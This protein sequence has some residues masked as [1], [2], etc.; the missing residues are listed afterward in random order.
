[1]DLISDGTVVHAGTFNGNPLAMAAA[2]ATIDELGRDDGEAYRRLT[3][4][5]TRLMEG[6]RG[7]ASA[8]G[9]PVLLQGPGPVFY[10]WLTDAPAVTD[11]AASARISRESYAWFAAAM[12]TAGVRVIPGGRWY[13]SCSHTEEDIDQTVHAAAAALGAVAHRRQAT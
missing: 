10:M 13:L 8:A 7:A 11:Y 5:G 6:I 2:L 3:G 9:V 12:L 1:M 4:L